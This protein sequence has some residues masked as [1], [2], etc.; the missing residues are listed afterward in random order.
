METIILYKYSRPDGGTTVSK[1]KP[2]HD[3]YKTIFRLIAEEGMILTDGITQTY[4]VDV[5]DTLFWDEVSNPQY[6]ENKEV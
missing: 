5:E 2:N 6:K 1:V 3:N 4:C